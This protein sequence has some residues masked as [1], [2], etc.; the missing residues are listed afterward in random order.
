MKIVPSFSNIPTNNSTKVGAEKVS[1]VPWK[2]GLENRDYVR[3]AD[4]ATPPIRKN[5][6]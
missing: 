6:H 1:V 2:P 3:R 5:R 4:H